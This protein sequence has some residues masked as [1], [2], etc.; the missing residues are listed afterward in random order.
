[1]SKNARALKSIVKLHLLFCSDLVA[2]PVGIAQ[3]QGIATVHQQDVSLP[4]HGDPKLFI[5]AGQCGERQHTQGLP[6]QF[7]H[8]GFGFSS[9]DEPLCVDGTTA[10]GVVR[11]GDAEGAGLGN[12]F[13]QQINQSVTNAVV[14]DASRSEQQF[15]V[16]SP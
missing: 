11:S 16:F 5:D 3:I 1:M 15:H 4:D 13:A 10:L 14:F 2:H 8:G 12:G 6:A 9:A 7:A